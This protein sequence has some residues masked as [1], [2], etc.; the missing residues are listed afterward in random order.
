MSKSAPLAKGQNGRDE[1]GRFIKGWKGGPGGHPNANKV[2]KIRAAVLRATS[3]KQVERIIRKLGKLAERGVPWA[4]KEYLKYVVG[5][6][7]H[8]FDPRQGLP[9]DGEQQRQGPQYT[10]QE[11]LIIARTMAAQAERELR[12]EEAIEAE[13]E[14]VRDVED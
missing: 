1:K 12:G 4:V 6:P 11:R 10:A 13:G 14:E 5:K 2:A 9:A 7:V 8:I 3:D